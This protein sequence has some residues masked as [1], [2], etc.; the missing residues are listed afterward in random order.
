MRAR[1][2][3]SNVLRFDA[4][5]ELALTRIFSI[6]D[7]HGIPPFRHKDGSGWKH[8]D[9]SEQ[10]GRLFMYSQSKFRHKASITIGDTSNTL[11]I[12]TST[13]LYTELRQV[14]SLGT[15][16]QFQI[17]SRFFV[18]LRKSQGKFPHPDLRPFLITD[19]IRREIAPDFAITGY[20]G[21]TENKC[22]GIAM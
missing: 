22:I 21:K 11:I 12:Y 13:M 3:L 19:S 16:A 2:I 7:T 17:P 15:G 14:N 6:G 20:V 1:V 4:A 9:L 5:A 10:T 8:L 18:K